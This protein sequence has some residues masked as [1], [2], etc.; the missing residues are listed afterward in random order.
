[1]ATEAKNF[2]VY[3]LAPIWIADLVAT[4]YLEDLSDRVAV[5]EALQWDDIVP[6][7][8]DFNAVYGGRIYAIPLDGDLHLA[9]YRA[10]LLQQQGLEPPETWEEY[11][12]IAQTFHGKDLDGDGEADYGSCIARND[13]FFAPNMIWSIA[14]A[15][16]QSQG[17]S[18]GVFFDTENMKPL[19]INKAFAS[20]LDILIETSRYGP[21][22]ELYIGDTRDL[23]LSGRCALTVDWTDLPVFAISSAVQDK[24]GAVILPGSAR[25]LDRASGELVD[26]NAGVC[27]YAVN[28]VNHAPY[29]AWGGWSGVVNA[30]ANPVVKNAAYAFL[31]YMSQPAQANVDVT[32]GDNGFNPYRS[33]Q[34][35]DEGPWLASGMSPIAV[36]NYLGATEQSL[37]SPNIVADLRVPGSER[38]RQLVF[39]RALSPFL[40]GE[41]TRDE[42]MQR[43]YDGWEEITEELGRD[44]QLEAYR[45]SLNITQ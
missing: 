16:L 31:S 27:P 19:V 15:F 6:F 3:V 25:V 21:P 28:G 17:S 43:I 40:A 8:R 11:L 45:D 33:S 37:S 26:C 39:D 38:Y 5:D 14:S 22:H 1:V 30:G 29:A 23:F 13:R 4:G 20:A 18:Q 9:Y 10:D 36:S 42:A 7:F 32:R 12:N 24:M 34:L 35:R 2:D 41:I 44:S